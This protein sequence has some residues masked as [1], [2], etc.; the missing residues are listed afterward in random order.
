MANGRSGGI[1][2]TNRGSGRVKDKVP[3]PNAGARA[4]QLNRWAAM[5][6][7]HMY[8]ALILVVHAAF[9]A[10]SQADLWL[11]ANEGPF[12]DWTITVTYLALLAALLY[13]WCKADSKVR[14]IQPP[15]GTA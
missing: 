8:L 2:L 6:P 13:L 10:W 1:R 4:A 15:R 7:A 9:G 11:N 14:R 5:S 3:S 12:H